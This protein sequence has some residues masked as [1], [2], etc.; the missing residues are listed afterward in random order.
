MPIQAPCQR[1][2]MQ[3]IH[4]AQYHRWGT[5]LQLNGTLFPCLVAPTFIAAKIIHGYHEVY[6]CT[7]KH[8]RQ[9]NNPDKPWYA[10][11]LYKT[12]GGPKINTPLAFLP[13]PPI[14]SNTDHVSKKTLWQFIPLDVWNGLLQ[15][16]SDERVK[17]MMQTTYGNGQ[18]IWK[19]C[20]G[21]V[22]KEE[23]FKTLIK[24][25]IAEL[26]AAKVRIANLNETEKQNF[27]EKVRL[28]QKENS[29]TLSMHAKEQLH[30]VQLESEKRTQEL[31]QLA[32]KKARK[33]DQV[34]KKA[35][36]QT[37]IL[38]QAVASAGESVTPNNVQPVQVPERLQQERLRQQQKMYQQYQYQQQA[39][40]A[41]QA[42]PAKKR[43]L[44]PDAVEAE[45][46]VASEA[47]LK[48][49]HAELE[50]I[51]ETRLDE[52]LGEAKV[53]IFQDITKKTG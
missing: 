37:Q 7:T 18:C 22:S 9:M 4:L 1:G 41:Q 49:T 53:R 36:Q 38:N 29:L 16:S 10:E 12:N 32:E 33:Q 15:D 52:A 21:D 17:S 46:K 39:R 6:I 45:T 30:K 13:P 28:Q 25:M 48:I 43:A 35:Q 51:I 20:R 50:K 5:A 42:Q 11:P 8:G 23:R 26:K 2:L 19:K 3:G 27:Q 34:L 24:G 14:Y 44:V 31:L 40:H 47:T